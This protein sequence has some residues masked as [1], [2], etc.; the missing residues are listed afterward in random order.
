MIRLKQSEYIYLKYLRK[1]LKHTILNLIKLYEINNIFM[2]FFIIHK[3]DILN[4]K[5]VK[6]EV[7]MDLFDRL[8]NYVKFVNITKKNSGKKLGLSPPRF[9]HTPSKSPAQNN[10]TE[11][12]RVW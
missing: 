4:N 10:T 2:I 5:C 12:T 1:H 3:I 7:K 6:K 11:P 9:E 8:N